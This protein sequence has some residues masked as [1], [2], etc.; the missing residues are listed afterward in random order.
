M[1]WTS[2]PIIFGSIF[3]LSLAHTSSTP[4]PNSAPL[5]TKNNSIVLIFSQTKDIRWNL[6]HCSNTPQS[7]PIAK[8][9]AILI[10]KTCR[11]VSSTNSSPT[12]STHILHVALISFMH[13]GF[14]TKLSKLLTKNNSGPVQ[15]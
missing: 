11:D 3:H 1:D 15:V 2:T 4:Q 9:T 5:L 7:S 10:S 6:K 8:L 14:I 13:S 12:N